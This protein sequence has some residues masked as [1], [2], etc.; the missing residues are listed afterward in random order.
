MSKTSPDTILICGGGVMQLPA[1]R[2]A[3]EEGLR[4]VVADGNPNCPGRR[5]ADVFEPIDLKDHSRLTACARSHRVQAVCTA[6]TDFSL[7]VARVAEAC[8]LP[9]VSVDAAMHATDKAL[10]RARLSRAGVTVPPYAVYRHGRITEGYDDVPLPAVVK[11]VASMGARGVRRITR[12]GEL[13]PALEAAM[14][15]SRDGRVIVESFIPGEEYS[16][17]CLVTPHERILCGIA[18][19]H[20]AIPPHFVE[21]GHTIPTALSS[22]RVELL[23][24]EFYSAVDAI[25]ICDGAAKGDIFIVDEDRRPGWLAGE[26]PAVVIGEIAARLSGGYMSGWTYPCSSGVEPTRG[27][28]RIALG[29][30]PRTGSPT[31]SDIAA[32]RAVMSIPGVL[33]TDI[34]LDRLLSMPGVQECFLSVTAGETV[35]IPTNNVEKCGNLIVVGAS[36]DELQERVDAVLRSVRIPLRRRERRTWS[37]L[38]GPELPAQTVYA[39]DPRFHGPLHAADDR[40]CEQTFTGMLADRTGSLRERG[41]QAGETSLLR[42][43]LSEVRRCLYAIPAAHRRSRE[44]DLHGYTRLE[45]LDR[46][47]DEY[48]ECDVFVDAGFAECVFVLAC[49]RGGLQGLRYV[50]DTLIEEESCRI[51]LEVLGQWY[52]PYSS[53]P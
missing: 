9:G 28:I 10:M 51:L 2:I 34:A 35:S 50:I 20:I 17:D 27:A 39:A 11:P 1:I 45:A 4:V 21:V 26:G 47:M 32:E 36:R 29:R 12:A 8:G 48:D 42:S 23:L 15:F 16:V 49:E 33:E 46:V 6:G 22:D 13:E 52:A 30:D 41:K 19:R 3:R 24:R 40:T 7:T 14:E 25:G 18:D 5:T 37:Y 44:R 43:S 53:S 38:M 31:R